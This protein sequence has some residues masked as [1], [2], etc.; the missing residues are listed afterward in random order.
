MVRRRY[1][2]MESRTV[3][4]TL[5][6]VPN[7][8][9]IFTADR[10]QK[11]RSEDAVIAFTWCVC[12]SVCMYVFGY[13]PSTMNFLSPIVRSLLTCCLLTILRR[14]YQFVLNNTALPNVNEWPLRL[15]MTKSAVKAFDTITEFMEPRGQNVS[16]FYVVRMIC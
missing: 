14:R 4:A 13:Q 5:Y 15:P 7:Q 2:A 9:M 1:V 8:H 12:L 6:Q 10:L 11:A 3:G 16:S